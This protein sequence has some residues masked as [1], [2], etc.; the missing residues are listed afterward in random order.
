M[1]PPCVLTPETSSLHPVCPVRPELSRNV[2]TLLM[3]PESVPHAGTLLLRPELPSNHP[4]HLDL[5]FPL[6]SISQRPD[7][8]NS[9][10]PSGIRQDYHT[11]TPSL[12]E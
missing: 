1:R 2:R 7:A 9:P 5:K 8:F 12:L 4:L 10:A 6:F 3:H 11:P